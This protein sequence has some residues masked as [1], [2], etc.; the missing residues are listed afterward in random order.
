[1]ILIQHMLG[2]TSYTQQQ[3]TPDDI[4]TAST[5]P[6]KESKH[7]IVVLPTAFAA[8]NVA[9]AIENFIVVVGVVCRV[10]YTNK[11]VSVVDLKN[12]GNLGRV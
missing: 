9:I 5:K 7:T 11:V 12:Y 2:E 4:G 3:P 6:K 10:D 8:T 1:M